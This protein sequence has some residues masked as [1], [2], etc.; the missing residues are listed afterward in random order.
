MGELFRITESG[1]AIAGIHAGILTPHRENGILK[2]YQRKEMRR[3]QQKNGIF[4]N[5]SN[6]PQ[7]SWQREQKAAALGFPGVAELRELAFPAV[8]ADAD[9]AAVQAIAAD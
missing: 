9:E 7:C 3:M 2:P 8:P 6:H 1:K 5:F 4:L